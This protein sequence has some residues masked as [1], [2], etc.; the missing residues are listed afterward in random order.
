MTFAS[1]AIVEAVRGWQVEAPPPLVVA[2]VL[3]GDQYLGNVPFGD[4]AKLDELVA[5]ALWQVGDCGHVSTGPYPF[6]P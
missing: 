6:R 5:E 2:I 1:A 4:L 3:M